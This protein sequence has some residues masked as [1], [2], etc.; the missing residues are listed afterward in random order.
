MFSHTSVLLKESVEGLNICANGVYVDATFGRGG[1]F[2]EILNKLGPSGKIIAV[3]RDPEAI[4]FAKSFKDPRIHVCHSNFSQIPKIL[5]DLGFFKINGILFDLGVSSP[6]IESHQ[7]GFSFMKNGPLDMRMNPQEGVSLHEWLLIAT[8][9]EIKSVLKNFGEERLAGPIASAICEKR[10]TEMCEDKGLKNTR[11]LAD[12]IK[13]IYVKKNYRKKSSI[14]PATKSFQAFRI[15]LN[16]EINELNLILKAVPTFL[17]VG[18]RI[19]IINFHSLEDRIVKLA[20][21]SKNKF[22]TRKVG[23]TSSQLALLRSINKEENKNIFIKEIKKVK[24]SKEELEKN[25]RSRSAI[26]R[27]AEV[28]KN[29]KNYN[30]ETEP[31]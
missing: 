25:K 20:I 24:P 11:E 16:N 3:D 22:A 23:I 21:K 17:K 4:S 5:Q 10:G 7:R 31:S 12:L 27:I 29:D 13:K 26:L 15:F 30:S 8:Y 9:E 19:S 18:G 28:V 2:L 1:H 6:Q 14:H